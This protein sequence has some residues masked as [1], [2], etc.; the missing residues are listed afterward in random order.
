MKIINN[1]GFGIAAIII[2]F[3]L[4]VAATII[5]ASFQKVELVD[6]NY[7]ANS[8]VY[9][10]QIDKMK[11]YNNLKD[12]IKISQSGEYLQIIFPKEVSNTSISGEIVFFKPNDSS[13][14]FKTKLKTDSVNCYQIALNKLVKGKWL[15]KIDWKGNGTEFYNEEEITVR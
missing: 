10:K 7:Y 8:L 11:N 5:F 1:W 13:R 14:D 9:Q 3:L 4:S 15:I 6:K 12:N 2:L